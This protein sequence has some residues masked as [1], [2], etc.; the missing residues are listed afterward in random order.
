[1][2]INFKSRSRSAYAL[3]IVLFMSLIAVIILGGTLKRTYGVAAMNSRAV[4]MMNSQNAAEA[5]MEMVFSRMQYDFQ[6]AGGM[7]MVSNNLSLYRGLYP[8]TS[9]D[10][11][12]GNFQFSDAQGTWNSKT[13]V[14]Q[15]GT[16][17]G[18]LPTAYSN[19]STFKSPVYRIVSNAK[20]LHG[21]SGA[22]GAAQEDIMLAL[23]PLTDFAIFY[24]GLL[25]FSTC[26]TMTVNG[27]VH[28]NTNIYVGAG[29]TATLTF[30][31]SVTSSGI[32]SAP[33]NDG[34]NIWGNP[35][36]YNS[37]WNT[38]FNSTPNFI[39]HNATIQ[40]SI[41]M[42]NTHSLIDVPA[43]NDSATVTGQQRLYNQAQV[44]ITVSNLIS[45][46]PFISNVVVSV[47]VQKAPTS[48]DVPG[49][50]A[51]PT[52]V[53]FTNVNINTASAAL[54]AQFP[55]LTL[56]NIFY[57]AREKTTNVTS[58]V[59]IGLYKTW[60]TNSTSPVVGKF[61]ADG[62]SGY[63]T[64]LFVNDVRNTTTA[65]GKKL[66]VLRLV[67]G[68][69][70]PINNGLGFSVAT[71]NPLYLLGN[72]NQTNASFLGTSNTSSGTV[73][74]AIMSDAFTVLSSA[75]SD[76]NSMHNTFGSG[77]GWGANE[78]TINAAVLTGNVPST[79]TDATHYSGGVHNLPRLLED[80]SGDYLWINTSMIN[81]YASTKAT[82]Q[83]INPGLGSY[84]V[85]PTRK[86][87]YDNNFSDPAK[88]PPG[89]PCALVALRYNWATPPP[90]TITYNVTP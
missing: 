62:S 73:P 88:V 8:Q 12:W 31:S 77:G 15:I 50:D 36:N 51:T 60:L 65:G 16:F 33:A 22:V 45:T 23:I 81:L 55:F 10:P 68:I 66:A 58:Q 30:N 79:G 25:E 34:Q 75:W 18:P 69:S 27:A 86:F 6:S 19:R 24:N 47:K 39:N 56:T 41:N 5:A 28:S 4:D 71:P 3:I 64:I 46:D 38:T 1:M 89:I 7:A 21:N 57:D 49:A 87:S 29:N 43:T 78:T 13:Y 40:I 20:L 35:T 52:I 42:T 85:P 67:N 84:Y 80:W 37:S 61:P 90:N 59:D 72:Y 14:S 9:Q 26:A 63:P 74:C 44:Q 54:Y 70:P 82:G 53:N 11:Y 17:T 83:F 76:Y 48:S 2:K 32:V